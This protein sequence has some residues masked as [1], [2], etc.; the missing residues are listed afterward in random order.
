MYERMLNRQIFPTVS[1]MTEYCG[2]NSELFTLLNKWLSE[3]YGTVQK[4]VFPYDNYHGWGI[5]HIKKGK[6]FC[7]IFAEKNA[8]TVMMKLSNKL[9]DT[10]Y[11]QTCNNK[12][13]YNGG[14][15]INYQVTC[16][17]DFDDI[18]EMLFIQ[19]S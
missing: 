2:D 6:L 16:S 7:N 14:D 9:F 4:I 15:W 13:P 5:S 12:H 18:R 8:F 10:I 1:E 19:C 17:Q 11:N 3:T